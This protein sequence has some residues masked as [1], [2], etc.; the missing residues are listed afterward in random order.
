MAASDEW[1][2]QTTAI[3]GLSRTAS[4][5]SGKNFCP[6]W[7][8]AFVLSPQAV[9]L[10]KKSACAYD[11][12]VTGQTIYAYVGG[13]PIS[14]VDP[15]GLFSW[16]DPSPPSYMMSRPPINITRGTPS[17]A[18]TC[19]SGGKNFSA[20]PGTNYNDVYR[21]GQNG[22]YD[23]IAA[24]EAIGHFGK[25]DFQRNYTDYAFI[26]AY[27]D[28]SNFSVGVYMRGAGFSRDRTIAIGT[29][30]AR[31]MSKNAG[32]AAQADYWKAGWDAAN[33]GNLSGICK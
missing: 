26:G 23:P 19:S 5:V 25:Y 13:N 17:D 15:Y 32:A 31:L 3:A 27:T 12:S 30:F 4:C 28:A 10:S 33:S 20:P 24:N 21:A 16:T 18:C 8:C 11:E 1:T 22:G 6:C 2:S 29:A 7:R 9:D 14:N